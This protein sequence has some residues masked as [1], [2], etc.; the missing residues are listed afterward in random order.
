MEAVVLAGGRGTRLGALTEKLP[1]PMVPV[2]GRPFL[3]FVLDHLVAQGVTR[4][5][6]SVGYL[7]EIIESYFGVRYR[8]AALVYVV[9][10]QAL[11]TGGGT[12]L[13]LERATKQLV[14]VVNGDTLFPVPFAD[15][16]AMQKSMQA[17]VV[18]ALKPVAAAGR[19]GQVQLDH[20]IV[21]G[22][23]EKSGDGQALVNGG[24]YLVRRSRILP[25]LPQGMSSLEYDLIPG[26]LKSHVVAAVVADAMFLDI[27]EPASYAL[28]QAQFALPESHARE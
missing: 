3:A 28:A 19:F 12:R 27:G 11:G 26:I 24:T 5:I 2:A 25:L 21:V 4:I 18:M 7:H 17:D 15:M 6:L 10:Q 23:Q 20:G 8:S 9:E 14:F 22:F 16:L 13:A 1:K